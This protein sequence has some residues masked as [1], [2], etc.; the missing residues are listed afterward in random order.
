M[1]SFLMKIK[2]CYDP[3][4]VVSVDIKAGIMN[5]RV[6][7]R[8]QFSCIN[9]TDIGKK[10][11]GPNPYS[12]KDIDKCSTLPCENIPPFVLLGDDI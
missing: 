9:T 11:E 5:S 10:I 4:L 3:N 2:R 1:R 8:I 7:K 12:L 6:F